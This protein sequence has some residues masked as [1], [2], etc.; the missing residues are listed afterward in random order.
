MKRPPAIDTLQ[1]V[2]ELTDSGMDQVMAETLA[3]IINKAVVDT[4]A[5]DANLTETKIRLEKKIDVQ[6]ANARAA[7]SASRE[8][9][10]KSEDRITR[11]LVLATSLLLGVF[12][13]LPMLEPYVRNALG[14][15]P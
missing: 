2:K 11:R 12:W 7:I 8:Y 15:A 10:T 4:T 3:R 9:M 14:S 6:D 13:L 1:V 5:T